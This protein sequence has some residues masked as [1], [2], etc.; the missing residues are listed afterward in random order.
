MA[1]V[2]VEG[3]IATGSIAKLAG[4]K[5]YIFQKSAVVKCHVITFQAWQGSGEKRTVGESDVTPYTTFTVYIVKKGVAESYVL[6]G[7]TI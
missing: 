5:L 4:G 7:C 2:R 1:A 6:Y 3:N